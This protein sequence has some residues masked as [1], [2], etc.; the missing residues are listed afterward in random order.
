[1]FGYREE[2]FPT[3]FEPADAKPEIAAEHAKTLVEEWLSGRVRT[4]V[5]TD[6]SGKWCGSTIIELGELTPQLRA[7]AQ[8]VRSFRPEQVEVRTFAK[9]QW[10][11]YP[12]E[13]EWLQAPPLS[14]GRT[15]A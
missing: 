1:M 4:A 9:R 2:V 3:P 6:A 8:S 5:L 13:P 11:S 14:P 12:V 7:A 15:P 10:R